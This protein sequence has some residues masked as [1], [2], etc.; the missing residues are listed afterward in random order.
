MERALLEAHFGC[1]RLAVTERSER[2]I[3]SYDLVER[4]I[5]T[6]LSER[7]LERADAEREL[8]RIAARACGIAAAGDLADYFRMPVKDVRRPIDE[9]V[10][11]RELVS[12]QVEGWDV[13]AYL[14]AKAS[15]PRSIPAATLLSPFDPLVWCR[16]RV[17][18]VFEFDYKLEIFVPPGKRRWGYYVLPFLLKD[19]LVA[20]VDLRAN[21]EDGVLEVVGAWREPGVK[22][23]AKELEVELRGVASWLGLDG[24]RGLKKVTD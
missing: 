12:C 1:G 20:R 7:M 14:W 9:L 15:L 8:V 21:R 5:P 23:V 19:R 17:A 22:T 3:R 6:E 4:V 10:E 13:P 2:F 18:R 24:V 16:A 11:S